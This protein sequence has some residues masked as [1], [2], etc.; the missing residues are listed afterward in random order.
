MDRCVENVRA[1]EDCKNDERQYREPAVTR[2]KKRDTR[3]VT[4]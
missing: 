1:L 4:F 3:H 2:I